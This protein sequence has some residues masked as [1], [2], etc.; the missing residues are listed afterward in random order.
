VIL[1][2]PAS[3]GRV[4]SSEPPQGENAVYKLLSAAMEVKK[5]QDAKKWRQIQVSADMRRV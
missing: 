5:L 4:N 1:W 2:H 3:G